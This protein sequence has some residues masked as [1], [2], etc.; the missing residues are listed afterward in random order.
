MTLPARV[1]RHVAQHDVER[2]R[3]ELGDHVSQASG[4]YQQSDITQQEN[5]SRVM[6]A[7]G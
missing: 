4:Q 1:W 6:K 5:I 2:R 7:L 3:S